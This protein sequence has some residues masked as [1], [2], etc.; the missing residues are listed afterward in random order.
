MRV[1]VFVTPRWFK[2]YAYVEGGLRPFG[3]QRS[4]RTC[5]LMHRHGL[6]V[7]AA[8]TFQLGH[9]TRRITCSCQRNGFF[10]LHVLCEVST[11]THTYPEPIVFLDASFCMGSEGFTSAP[12]V[13]LSYASGHNDMNREVWETD[14]EGEEWRVQYGQY[15]CSY[16]R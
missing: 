9:Y 10:H 16:F 11:T 7:L 1:I 5:W 3:K 12:N 15:N 6:L 2:V 13:F 8:S 14:C 4:Q